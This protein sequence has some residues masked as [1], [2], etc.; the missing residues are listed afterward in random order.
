MNPK[1]TYHLRT[2]KNGEG[3]I[4][5]LAVARNEHGLWTTIREVVSPTSKRPTI[6]AATAF[7][8]QVAEEDRVNRGVKPDSVRLTLAE[9]AGDLLTSRRATPKT[10][11]AVSLDGNEVARTTV[12]TGTENDGGDGDA[13]TSPVAATA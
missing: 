6:E 10:T 3:Q 5:K 8:I 1:T 2:W 11:T 13:T 4:T 9:R 7:A 12:A